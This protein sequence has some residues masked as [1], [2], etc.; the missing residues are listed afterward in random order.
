MLDELLTSAPDTAA[1]HAQIGQLNLRRK[2]FV[3][4]RA[5]PRALELERSNVDARSRG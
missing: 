5:A 1:V 2:D 3:R 4:A